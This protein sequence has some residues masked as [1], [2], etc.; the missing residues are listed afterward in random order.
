LR[1]QRPRLMIPGPVDVEDEV[2]AALAEPIRPHYGPEW[3]EIYHEALERL[4]QIFGTQNDV[5]LMVGPG[6]AGLDAALGSMAR[7][8]EKVLVP[9]NGFFGQ[10]MAT[11]AQSYGLDVRNIEA[12]MGKP[13]DPEAV[14]RR[15]LAEPDIQVVAF[16]HLETSTGVLNPLQEIVAVVKEF[17]VPIVVDAVSSMG[18]MPLPVDELGID[19]CITVSNK[20][21]AAPAGLVFISVS[22]R[23]WDHM[24]QR[25]GRAHGWYLNLRTWKDYAINW[26]SWHPYPTTLPTNNI[27]ALVASLRRILDEGLELYYE[28]HVLAAQ[29]VRAGLRG[30]GFE[31][32][33]PEAHASPLI[34]TVRG[35]QGMDIE[36]FRRFLREEWQV[37][38]AGGLEELRGRVFRV[39]HI[40]K[41]ASME[42][43]EHFLRGVEAYLSL[44]GYHVPPDAT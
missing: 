20:C 23:A 11:V 4:K 3:V 1:S 17:G 26:A 30:L 27:V 24:D 38:I 8:G 37:M 41:A 33:M 22:Q 42:Y 40:G 18:G 39:G 5:I 34:T 7:T 16:V 13:L 44:Q 29:T 25:S 12:P 28:R 19:L 15:L 6:S 10:R 35:L 32:L 31:M 21:L 9:S 14:R 43:I 2:L 36:E